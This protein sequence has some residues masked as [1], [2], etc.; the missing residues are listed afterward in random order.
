MRSYGVAVASLVIN[1]PLKWT[2]N[3]LSQH[4]V[5]GVISARRGIARRITFPALLRLA[6]IRQLHTGLGVSVANGVRLANQ[7]LDSDTVGVHRSGQLRLAVD[8]VE[9]GRELDLRLEEVLE[10]AP[11]PK[12]GRPPRRAN[13]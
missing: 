5:T 13:T 1:A 11:S 12:R 8:L 10:S 7:L 6:I 2:D 4:G 3:T 9:L